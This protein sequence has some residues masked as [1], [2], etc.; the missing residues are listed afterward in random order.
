MLILLYVVL[1]YV[2]SWAFIR[3][4]QKFKI[5]D[6]WDIKFCKDIFFLSPILWIMTVGLFLHGIH[7]NIELKFKFFSKIDKLLFPEEKN[8]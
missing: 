2:I 1:S 4:G 7:L 6:K 5:L 3:I 8:D